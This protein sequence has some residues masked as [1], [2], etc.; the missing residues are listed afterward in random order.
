MSCPHEGFHAIRTVYD[1]RRGILVY[2][3]T[4]EECGRRLNEARRE[5]YRPAFDPHGPSRFLDAS[6]R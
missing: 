3:W 6:T 2:F 1:R 4:C 5:D